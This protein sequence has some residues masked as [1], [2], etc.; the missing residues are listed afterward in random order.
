MTKARV[1]MLACFLVAFAAGTALGLLVG[2][3]ALAPHSRSRLSRELDLTPQQRE[4]MRQIWSDVMRSAP[5]DEYERRQALRTQRDE[6]I[7]AL[8]AEEQKPRYEEVMQEYSRK[9]DELA[10]ERQELFQKATERT[11]EILTESQRKKYEELLEKARGPRSR[12]GGRPTHR[13][14]RGPGGGPSWEQRKPGEPAAPHDPE[15]RQDSH[16]D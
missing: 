9:V 1:M 2:R 8:L 5:Q 11:K 3:P 13:P 7:Q 6:A 10:Q 12:P 16:E 4:Q 14:R 15:N